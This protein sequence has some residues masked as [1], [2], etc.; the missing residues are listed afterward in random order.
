MLKRIISALLV[1]AVLA[2]VPIMLSGCNG[3]DIKTERH[4]EVKDKV[5]SQETVIE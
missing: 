3:D 4:V 2:F 1:V 5:I